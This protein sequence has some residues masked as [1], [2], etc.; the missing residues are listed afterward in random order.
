[1][2]ILY[3]MLKD[4]SEIKEVQCEMNLQIYCIGAVFI[5]I[6]LFKHQQ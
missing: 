1:M 5:G 2:Q 3:L 4:I 6:S